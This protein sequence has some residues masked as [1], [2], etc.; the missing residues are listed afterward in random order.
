MFTILISS[1]IRFRDLY[2]HTL[3]SSNDLYFYQR[4]IIN[5]YLLVLSC[6]EDK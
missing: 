3:I 1:V 2:I 6:R 4:H 5:L